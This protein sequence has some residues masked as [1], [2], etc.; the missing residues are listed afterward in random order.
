MVRGYILG[1]YGEIRI[2]ES[3]LEPA[4]CLESSVGSG[5]AHGPWPASAHTIT[6]ALQLNT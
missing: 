5:V 1:L 2:M 6:E 4:E 3:I